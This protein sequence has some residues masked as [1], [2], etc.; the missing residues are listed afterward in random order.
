MSKFV[1][2]AAVGA[3][4]ASLGIASGAQAATSAQANAS[5]TILNSLAVA[6]SPTD[7]V[8]YRSIRDVIG[9]NY[10]KPSISRASA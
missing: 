7:N 6:V 10:P 4:M 2:Y 1:R 8:L 9:R 3:A 5:A